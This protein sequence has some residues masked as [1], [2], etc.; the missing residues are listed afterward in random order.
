MR[1]GGRRLPVQ[2][3]RSWLCNWPVLKLRRRILDLVY[4]RRCRHRTSHLVLL[5]REMFRVQERVS[6]DGALEI[7]NGHLLSRLLWS[8]ADQVLRADVTDAPG[9]AAFRALRFSTP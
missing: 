1:V 4:C 8:A 7:A 9:V 6:D 5:P 2:H 3:Y